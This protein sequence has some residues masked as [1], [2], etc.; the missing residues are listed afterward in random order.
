MRVLILGATGRTGKLLL[1]ETLARGY[2]VNALVRD[3]SKVAMHPALTLFEGLPTDA[4]ALNK[5]MVGCE[6]ILSALNISRNS[7]F[8]WAKLRTPAN[9]L[10]ETAKNIIELA[11][12][13]GISRVILTSAW[14]TNDTLKDIPWWF[15]WVIENSNVGVA[16]RDHERQEDMFAASGLN[17]TVVRPVGLT[18]SSKSKTVLVSLANN[19]KPLLTISRGDVAKFMVDAL[20][21]NLFARQMPVISS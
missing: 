16:Y 17:Y 2:A 8:P 4:A 10:F 21:G 12:Q 15:K 6:A 9:F 20:L 18:N 1:Q 13:H 5:A 11:L 3:K 14:G 19:P 7:D